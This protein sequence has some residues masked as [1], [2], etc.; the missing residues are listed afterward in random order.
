MARI[1]RA[2]PARL[3]LLACAVAAFF[4]SPPGANAGVLEPVTGAVEEVVSPVAE[5]TPSVQEVGE[6]VTSTA[7]GVTA[8]ITPSA[9]K[10]ADAAS[11]PPA[12]RA[13]G[14]PERAAALTGKATKPASDAASAVGV[15]SAT[16]AATQAAEGAVHAATEGAEA[17]TGSTLPD[18]PISSAAPDPA[19]AP[20]SA[21]APTGTVAPT[22]PRT[23]YVP[24]PGNDGSTG[25][26]LPRWIAYVWP[27]VALTGPSLANFA[28][29]WG[30]AIVRLATG[31]SAGNSAE[32]GVAAVHASGGRP[33][34][35]GSSPLFSSI[36]SEAG[37]AFSS[38]PTP[39]FIYLGLLV[40][41]VI[42]VA[43]AVRREIAVGRRQ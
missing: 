29:S 43:L 18:S 30:Q 17:A 37:H 25:A 5:A 22:E 4:F 24:P 15:Q 41:A 32:G 20:A 36:P 27:A 14:L 35:A 21:A 42:A 39:V 7:H 6:T 31:A 11:S 23:T 10:T 26:P 8:K 38:V 13:G 28:E 12:D 19:A 1:S 34:A 2:H 3:A 40:L 33:E 16:G 9:A